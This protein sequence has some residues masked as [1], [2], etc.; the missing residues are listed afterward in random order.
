LIRLVVAGRLH[1]ELGRIDDWA[2]T[3]DA[4]EALLNRDIHGNVVLT[5]GQ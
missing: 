2:R 4:I 1:P 5:I 3:G